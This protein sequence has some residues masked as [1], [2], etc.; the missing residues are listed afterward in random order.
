[1]LPNSQ[2][3]ASL[4]EVKGLRRTQKRKAQE[5]HH[6]HGP[7]AVEFAGG[8]LGLKKGSGRDGCG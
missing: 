8:L 2:E 3:R 7:L 5:R 4:K 1:V 6:F